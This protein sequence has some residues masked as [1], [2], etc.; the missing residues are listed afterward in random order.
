[1]LVALCL[2]AVAK[3]E[4]PLTVDS[5]VDL[6]KSAP[7]GEGSAAPDYPWP[8]LYPGQITPQSPHWDLELLYIQNRQDEG[9]VQARAAL[10]A[11]PDDPELYWMLVRFMFEV[12]ERVP[13]SD[14][15]FDKIAWY[16]EMVALCETG[17]TL[18]PGHIHLRFARGVANGRLG[19]TRGVLAS[20]FLAKDMEQDWLDV[21]NSGFIYA[22]PHAEELLPCDAHEALGVFY[23]LVPDWWIVSVLSGTRGSLEKSIHHLELA[24]RCSGGRVIRE[25]KELAVSQI[26]YGQHNGDDAMI[27]AG[28]ANLHLMLTLPPHTDT[29]QVDLKHGRMLLADPSLACAYSRDGQQELD[30]TTLKQP[31]AP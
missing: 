5:A 8:M 4:P 23:R 28:L 15:T 22:T 2:A 20:L 26:C 31:T 9:V 7:A 25:R 16:Q 29:E 30:E 18:A 13:R 1:M 14:T 24:N 3:A 21:A 27:Q 19:T 10:T 17:L 12:G 6:P 11:H